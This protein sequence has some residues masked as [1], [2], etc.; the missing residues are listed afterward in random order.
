[1]TETMTKRSA[2]AGLPPG[3]PVHVG[4]RKR[5]TVRI[6]VIDY[7]ADH[8]L[9]KTVED[10]AACFRFKGKRTTTWINVDGVHDAPILDALGE[11]YGLHPLVREDIMNTEQRPKLEDYGDYLYIVLKALAYDDQ[12][13]E[14]AT[15]QIS[16][17]LGRNFVLSFQEEAGDDF[18]ALR[19]RLRA[20]DRRAR[21]VGADYLTYALIDA[22]VDNYFVI[23][24]HVG[25]KIEFLEDA[26]VT[27]PSR[28]TLHL[29]HD[30]KRAMIFLRK[31]VWPLREVIGGLERRDS[32]LF[33]DATRTYI[34]DVYDHVIQV[35]DTVETYRE[36]ISG[37]LDIYLSSMSNKLNEVMK[38]LTIIA[39]VFIPLTFIAGVYGMNFKF[40]PELGWRWA[41]PALWVVMLTAA[42]LM[43]AFFRRRKWL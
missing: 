19:A 11:C 9:E 25:E 40:M 3:T 26:L 4:E 30:L 32:P 29:I 10:V 42:V 1:M 37:V 22:V 17:V 20:E 24:E 28:E 16:L 13:V 6:T 27:N 8:F 21:K 2:K 34:R 23:L 36:M 18:D 31:A 5:Q 43:L 7:D 38:V 14:V 12:K 15:E 35:I 39:T 33:R 41:Y